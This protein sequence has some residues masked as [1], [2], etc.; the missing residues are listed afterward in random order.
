MA[1][2]NRILRTSGAVG[3]GHQDAGCGCG[4][5]GERRGIDQGREVQSEPDGRDACDQRRE[6]EREVE[7]GEDGS[8]QGG[9]LTGRGQG[10]GHPEGS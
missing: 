1:L 3:A 6:A 4:Q 10:S 7:H 8:H 2:D 9:P 5:G